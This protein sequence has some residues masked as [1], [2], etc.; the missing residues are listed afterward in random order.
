MPLESV[1]SQLQI[2]RESVESD[3]Q[4]LSYTNRFAIDRQLILNRFPLILCQYN[5]QKEQKYEACR[6]L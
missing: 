4:G 6:G 3:W 2:N 1:G 5:L